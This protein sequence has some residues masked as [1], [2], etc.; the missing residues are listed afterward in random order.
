MSSWIPPS[1]NWRRGIE[2]QSWL[3]E[4]VGKGSCKLRHKQV[5]RGCPGRTWA[6]MSKPPWDT[7]GGAIGKKPTNEGDDVASRGLA[8]SGSS[9]PRRL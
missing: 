8:R 7:M 5:T 4:M 9:G 2:W 6:T 1:H 3:G